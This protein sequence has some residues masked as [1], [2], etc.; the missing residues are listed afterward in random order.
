MLG[1]CLLEFYADDLV[2]VES[3]NLGTADSF[4]V[5]VIFL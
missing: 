1:R 2:K 3:I 5:K 4:E